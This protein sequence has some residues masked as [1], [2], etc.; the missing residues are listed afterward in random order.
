MAAWVAVDNDAVAKRWRPL[1]SAELDIV[2]QIIEDA[3]DILEEELEEIGITGAPVPTDERWERRYVR[4]VATMV[5]RVLQNPDALLSESID[6]YEY[7][8]DRAISAG[9]LYLAD[10][11]LAK[12]R[13]RSRASF[14]ITPG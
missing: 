3:Q 13:R 5:K 10:D 2:G 14:S 7:R 11:E 6:D 1:T 9:A 8:R 12:F 4:T